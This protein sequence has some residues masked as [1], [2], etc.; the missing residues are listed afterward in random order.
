MDTD[1]VHSLQH[2]NPVQVTAR[3]GVWHAMAAQHHAAVHPDLMPPRKLCCGVFAA[4]G[5]EDPWGRTP[6]LYFQGDNR[7]QGI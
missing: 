4:A 2:S 6:T 5:V 1:Q 3:S 7:V